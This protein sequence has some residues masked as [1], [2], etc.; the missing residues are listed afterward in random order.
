[1][2][3]ILPLVPPPMRLSFDA[4]FLSVFNRENSIPS[5]VVSKFSSSAPEA[6]GMNNRATAATAIVLILSPSF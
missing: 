4:S 5:A 6:V 3:R 2:L 1:M